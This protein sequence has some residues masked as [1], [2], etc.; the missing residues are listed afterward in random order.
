[1]AKNTFVTELTFNKYRASN[2]K[3]ASVKC[4][5]SILKGAF[6]ETTNK[7][8]GW[9]KG[10]ARHKE[11]WGWNDNVG[12]SISKKCKLW[13]EWKEQNTDKEAHLHAKKKT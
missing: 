9:T 1:M 12:N 4:Y 8:C 10:P 11:T 5:W 13:K 6:L 3:D 2:Q 7:S